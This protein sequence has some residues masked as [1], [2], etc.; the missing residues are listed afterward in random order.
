MSDNCKIF[1][2]GN[3]FEEIVESAYY[4]VIGCCEESLNLDFL[5]MHN[6]V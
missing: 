1:H 2:C 5:V 6:A 4:S 3:Y